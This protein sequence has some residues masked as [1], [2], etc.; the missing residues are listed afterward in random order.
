MSGAWGHSGDR[1]LEQVEMIDVQPKDVLK[2]RWSQFIYSGH[3]E[4]CSSYFQSILALFPRRTG[5]SFMHQF[6]PSTRAEALQETNPIP[7]RFDT[8][9]A[10]WEWHRPLIEAENEH[11]AS[12]QEG[13][14]QAVQGPD[15]KRAL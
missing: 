3:D 12:Q 15:R 14:S 7:E 1:N 5:E 9:E 10:M 6:L 2:Q 11:K 8:L 4:Y 13:S